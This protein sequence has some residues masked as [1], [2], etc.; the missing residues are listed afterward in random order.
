MS[1]SKQY[2]FIPVCLF[3]DMAVNRVEVIENMIHYGVYH[4]A[5]TANFNEHTLLSK[6]IYA[7]LRKKQTIPIEIVSKI[8]KIDGDL[9]LSDDFAFNSSGYFEPDEELMEFLDSLFERDDT[10]K[11]DV[12]EFA[13]VSA[14]LDFYGLTSDIGKIIKFGRFVDNNI[15]NG[16]P[17][18]NVRRDKL[19]E[20]YNNDKSERELIKYAVYLSI[21]SIVGK[22]K[23][24][25]LTNKKMVFARAF[26]YR[27][28]KEICELNT[29]PK[30][31]EKY[32]TETVSRNILNE[33]EDGWPLHAYRKKGMRGMYV[34][35]SNLIERKALVEQ[36]LA[37]RSSKKSRRSK[38]E[39]YEK[40]ALKKL[41]LK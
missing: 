4:Y 35:K 31:Y 13:K 9:F 11:N 40:L 7:A 34:A 1:T 23:T 32:T 16:Y 3:R 27:N 15:P 2:F 6:F 25:K 28:D 37:K 20:F 24:P 22:S 19:F 17:R 30:L 26:G 29:K 10:L 14:S 41:N 5:M 21:L 12:L 36:V 18:A 38:D 39:E 8:E 33:V